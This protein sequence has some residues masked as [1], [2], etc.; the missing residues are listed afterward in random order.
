MRTRIFSDG[1]VMCD[2]LALLAMRAHTYVRGGRKDGN[3]D[4]CCS[5]Q[6]K[7]VRR[8]GRAGVFVSKFVLQ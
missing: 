1:A 8:S 2:A 6:C 5:P 7:Y 3:R 4:P